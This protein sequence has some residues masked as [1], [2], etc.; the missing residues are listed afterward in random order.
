MPTFP[1]MPNINGTLRWA[2]LALLAGCGKVQ[3]IS[4]A[5]ARP[6][7]VTPP[8]E[9]TAYGRD[10]GGSR[11]SPAA[12]ITRENIS[13]LRMTWTYRSGDRWVDDRS[14]D[15]KGRFEATPLFVDGALFFATP[16]GT[17]IALDG[18]R[19]TER[20][21]F[22]PRIDIGGNYGDFANRG[23][24][25]WLDGSRPSGGVCR[26]RIFLAAIDARLIALDAANGKRCSDF[27]IGG[28]IDLTAGLLNKPAY[29]GE[30]QVTSPPAVIGGLI[31]VGSAVA[32][33][34]RVDAPSGV[35][36]AYDARSGALQWSWEPIPRQPG[37][38]G[39]DTWRGTKA[40]TSGAANA[41]S[42]IS[43]DSA[44]GLVFIPV[45]SASP[46]FYGGERLGTN[47]FANS[48]VALRANTGAV[49]W[50]FQVVHHD[51]W[52]YDVPAQPVLITVSRNGR[53]VAAVAVATKMGHVFVLDRDTGEPLYPVEERPVP[54]SDLPGEEAWPTQPFP[55]LPAPLTP[56]RLTASDAWGVTT[57]EREACRAKMTGL[58]A[59]GIFT[60]PSL[61]GTI[62]FPG[63]IGGSYW[64]GMGW[65]PVH[66][67]L[68]GPTN[69]LAFVVRQIPR[70][71]LEDEAQ[72]APE[73][74]FGR[75][76]GTPYGMRRDPLLSPKGIPCNPPPWGTV[77]AIDL[78]TGAKKWE[79]PFGWFPQLR[80]LEGYRSWG[81]ISL[82][83]LMITGGGLVFASG[84]RDEHLHAFDVQTGREL[85][86]SALPAGGNAMPMTYQTSTGRQFVVSAAGGHD[87]L[88]TTIGD[89]L[90]AYSLPQTASSKPNLAAHSIADRYDGEIHLGTNRFNGTWTFAKTKGDSI[91]GRFDGTGTAV[92][93]YLN[94]VLAG[95]FSHDTLRLESHWSLPRRNCSGIFTA[96]GVVA[97]D[98]ALIEGSLRL[99]GSCGTHV[100]VG[101]FSLFAPVGH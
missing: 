77:D 95:T 84:G 56:E 6:I 79:S 38:A 96:V 34:H 83:G 92:A 20:W 81:S 22:D 57:E 37:M 46:D 74:D 80:G 60:P 44:R 32:D 9:W 11:F 70:A 54:P 50:H 90:V 8:I 47:L 24:S 98:G 18:E 21:R 64:G 91:A 65:D 41:W 15:G 97:N 3:T 25:T 17:V 49:V 27:G 13:E 48:V 1:R 86:N 71:S 5:G 69:R 93:D 89:Y 42:V 7:D 73:S 94:G 62:I 45:G 36:R 52:D 53:D 4:R 67:L 28:E 66:S 75:Q 26:R 76:A 59:D 10:G 39:Y 87:K 35:V 88:G 55:V 33:N 12:Q 78:G 61:K 43:A 72:R 51:L 2:A 63:N 40:H 14:G 31:V 30:Y 68:I 85:W 29:K 99:Q 16:F 19:G 58:R 100:E 101:S 23:V 82:G